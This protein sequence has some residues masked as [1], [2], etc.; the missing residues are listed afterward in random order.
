MK[1]FTFAEICE[2]LQA[3]ACRITPLR[4]GRWKAEGDVMLGR[5]TQAKGTSFDRQKLLQ[6]H[7]LFSGLPAEIIERLA[8]YAVVKEVKRGT[9]IFSKGDVGNSL[10]AVCEGT[11]KMTS[12]SADGKDAVF[13]WMNQ[14]AIFGEIALLDGRTRTANAVA[15]TDCQLMVIDRRDF[16]PLLRS[17]QELAIK[18][19][20]VLC[21]R[22]RRTSEQVE[23]IMFLDL[24]GRL[25]KT[26]LRLTHDA[27]QQDRKL[28]ITQGEIAEIIGM[29]RES[30]N[31]QLRDW[32][33]R[34]WI[35]LERGG[36]SVLQPDAL[37]TL[38]ERGRQPD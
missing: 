38:A 20:D 28:A 30:T 27:S 15:A 12:P 1:Q 29:S 25:A 8:S 4:L 6:E 7:P 16:L 19:I 36:I 18:I 17:Q 26:L 5:E 34:K 33:E 22:L 3:E 32:Q 35:R 37:M 21:G 2:E 13:N 9:T 14:G 31:K 23:D 24:P 10:F 11:V